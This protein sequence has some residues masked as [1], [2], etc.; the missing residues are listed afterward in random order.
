[1]IEDLVGAETSGRSSTGHGDLGSLADVRP[2]ITHVGVGRRLEE[3]DVGGANGVLTRLRATV[4]RVEMV[5][6]TRLY[7]ARVTVC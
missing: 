5:I 7:N 3:A 4:S 2:Q 1:M 6:V